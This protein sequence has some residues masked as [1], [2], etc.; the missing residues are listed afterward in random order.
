MVHG[1]AVVAENRHEEEGELQYR[2]LDEFE[3]FNDIFVPGGMIE[4]GEQTDESE[5]DTD[6][7]GLNNWSVE[8]PV[9]E[10]YD[11]LE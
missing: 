11:A 3:A 2:M 4:V 5:K 9:Q 7:D 10:V 6:S 8:S 1:W